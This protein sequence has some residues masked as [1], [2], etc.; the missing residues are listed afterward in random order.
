MGPTLTLI[1]LDN[2]RRLAAYAQSS[3]DGSLS[4]YINGDK[5]VLYSFNQKTYRTSKTYRQYGQYSASSY[6]P[7][8][9][10]GHDFCMYA[11]MT[12]VAYCNSHS[13]AGTATNV[14]VCGGGGNVKY[15]E[16]YALGQGQMLTGYSTGGA[17]V[18]HSNVA[19]EQEVKAVSMVVGYQPRVDLWKMCYNVDVDTKNSQTFHAQCDNVGTAFVSQKVISQTCTVERIHG[20]R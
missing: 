9:G 15:L 11:D 16:V 20:L 3:W 2:G 17:R 13:F 19:S 5:N 4:N 8:F 12:K 14:D 1:T 7:T 6:G 18:G 10:G